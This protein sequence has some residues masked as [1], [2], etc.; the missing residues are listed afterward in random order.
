MTLQETMKKLTTKRKGTYTHIEF[1]TNKILPQK[2]NSLVLTKK[3]SGCYRL[4]ISYANLK[5]NKNKQ[6]G[7]MLYG[8]FIE[9]F[10]NYIIEYNGKYYLRVYTTHHKTKVQYFLDGVE[11]T[12]EKLLEM[13]ILKES[14]PTQ[15]F[16]ISL[17]NIINIG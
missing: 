11:Y 13:G 15:C 17:E 6:T 8:S 5:E 1:E 3:C 4:G 2:H 7:P 14:K 10:N 9:D 16:N 12:K